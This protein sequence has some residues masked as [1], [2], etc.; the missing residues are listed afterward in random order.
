MEGTGRC[1]DALQ[2]VDKKDHD[3]I[4]DVQADIEKKGK[5]TL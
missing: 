5:Q 4:A 3:Q 1:I 2:D